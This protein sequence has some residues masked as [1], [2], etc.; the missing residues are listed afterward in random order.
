MEEPVKVADI[1]VD[2]VAIDLVPLGKEGQGDRDKGLGLSKGLKTQSQ[3]YHI[4]W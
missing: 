2:H 1:L 3:I 4:F